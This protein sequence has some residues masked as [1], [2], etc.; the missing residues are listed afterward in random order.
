[1]R[2]PSCQQSPRSLLDQVRAVAVSGRTFSCRTCGALLKP[3]GGVRQLAAVVAGMGFGASIAFMLRGVL[4]FH[5]WP[6][7]ALF[8]GIAMAVSTAFEHVF[9]RYQLVDPGSAS[10]LPSAK[11]NG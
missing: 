7:T 5:G 8:V 6:R 9:V 11:L 10:V 1:V 4:P 3:E 2:C